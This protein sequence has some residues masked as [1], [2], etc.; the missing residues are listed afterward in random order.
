MKQYYI[1]VDDLQRGPFSI[2]E[3]NVKGIIS[4]TL[5]WEQD[6][7]NWTEARNIEVLSGII[8]KSPP[9][10]P[11]SLTK[12]LQ[13]E[14]QITKKKENLITPDNEVVVA[15]ETKSLFRLLMYGLIIGAFSFLIYFFII[16]D[17]TRWINI[18][19][20]HII[21]DSGV[22]RTAWERQRDMLIEKSIFSAFYTFLIATGLLI[23]L[24]YTIK[25]TKW[26]NETAKK[27]LK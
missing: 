5:V 23:A 9:P 6:M 11:Q 12:P 8:Q 25:G 15:K 17:V 27:E 22:T 16:Y 10:I 20:S 2:D 19:Y 24:R 13:V 18:D 26:V 21:D 14:T 4:S 7:E 1:I 3:L